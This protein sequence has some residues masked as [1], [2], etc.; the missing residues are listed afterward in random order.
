MT[1]KIWAPKC[2]MPGCCNLVAYHKKKGT[3]FKWKMFCEPH[4]DPAQLKGEADRW[5]LSQGCSNTDAHHGFKCTSHI[6]DASQLDINHIDGDRR[7]QEPD[8]LEILCKVC[9]QRVTVD[10]YHHTTR[11][12]NRVVL[13]PRL[14]EVL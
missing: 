13:N 11:Y 3:N 5:K 4:R 2:A 12:T 1:Y 6:T 10:N 9:H 14:F 7:N 8:N